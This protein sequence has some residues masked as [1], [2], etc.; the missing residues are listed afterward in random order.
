LK[1]KASLGICAAAGRAKWINLP[2]LADVKVN[3]L[4]FRCTTPTKFEDYLTFYARFERTPDIC[5]YLSD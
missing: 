2:S 4:P 3:E 5:S 1:A